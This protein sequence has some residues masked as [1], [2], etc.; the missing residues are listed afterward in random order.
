MYPGFLCA[1]TT[2]S[3]GIT[4]ILLRYGLKM[5]WHFKGSEDALA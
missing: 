2:G 3:E 5:L 4:F 1:I